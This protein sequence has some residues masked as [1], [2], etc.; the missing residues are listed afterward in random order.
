ME[1]FLFRIHFCNYFPR[2]DQSSG[3]AA[4]ARAGCERHF[5]GERLAGE[6][7]GRRTKTIMESVGGNGIF[8]NGRESGAGLH[9]GK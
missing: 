2:Y 4:L 6:V 5:D 7:A 1:V 8:L 9:V 3:L